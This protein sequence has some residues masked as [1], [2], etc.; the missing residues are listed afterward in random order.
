ME[1][2]GEVLHVIRGNRAIAK[3]KAAPKIGLKVFDGKGKLIGKIVDVFGPVKSPYIEVEV[4]G[5]DP[6]KVVSSPIYVPRKQKVMRG[7]GE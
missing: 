5:Q 2:I 6:K 1:K 7:R 4:E 3:V